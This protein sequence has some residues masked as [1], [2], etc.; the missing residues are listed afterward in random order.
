MSNTTSAF[1]FRGS[2]LTLGLMSIFWGS[3]LDAID[4]EMCNKVGDLVHWKK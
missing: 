2:L 4:E 1:H 3:P